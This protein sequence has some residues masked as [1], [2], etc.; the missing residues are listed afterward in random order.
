MRE[1]AATPWCAE[2]KKSTTPSVASPS[3]R[4]F[5]VRPRMATFLSASSGHSAN[6]SMVV[7]FT[8]A[9]NMRRR[10]RKA[11][12]MGDMATA[13]CRLRLTRMRYCAKTLILVGGS[14]FLRQSPRHAL[15]MAS[16]SSGT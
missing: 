3:L 7:Q 16:M 13:M 4:S 2:R 5:S 14:R 15:V 10:L 12:P 6:Q 9:G 11:S 8:S 1:A